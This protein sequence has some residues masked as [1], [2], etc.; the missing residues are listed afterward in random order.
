MRTRG[1][2]LAI[3]TLAFGEIVPSVIWH[4]P[5]WTGGA[6]GMSGVCGAAARALAAGARR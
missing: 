5:D 3:V 2:Y 1:E 4:L 6:R